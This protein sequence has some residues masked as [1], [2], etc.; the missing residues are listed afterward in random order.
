MLQ[1]YIFYCDNGKIF[2]SSEK[3]KNI[4]EVNSFLKQIFEFISFKANENENFNLE[5]LKYEYDRQ[6]IS[7]AYALVSFILFLL[8]KFKKNC[9]IPYYKNIS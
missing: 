4:E 6:R 3:Q 2:N 1:E 5:N 7:T 8:K 9:L